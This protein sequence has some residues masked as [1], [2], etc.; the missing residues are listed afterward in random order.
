MEL[1][2]GFYTALG[3]PLDE[4]GNLVA[5]SLEKHIENQITVAGASGLLLMGS[6][7]IEAYLKNDTFKQTAMV[8][9]KANA[10]RLPLFVGAM[11][12]SVARVMEKI[13]MLK[14]LDIDGV[15]LTTPYYATLNDNEVV[16]WFTT[17]ADKSPFPIYLYDLAVITKTKIKLCAIEA[18]INHKN[19][20]GIKTA[21]WELITA[22]ERKFPD[23][24]FACLYSGLDNFDYA[25][26]LGITKNLDGMFCCMPKTGRAMYDCIEAGDLKGARVHLD[27]ILLLRNTM[28]S[29]GLMQS[30]TFLMNE[31]GYEGNFHQDY[32]LPI[33]DEA[34]ATLISLMK[35]CGEI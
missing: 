8:G 6:M 20:K 32:T 2:S 28:I 15:V 9:V 30:F 27:N 12:N 14:G 26:M 22:I 18:L 13:D 33:T 4:C 3:T 7:G 17:I 19:I 25:N 29:L 1:K 11:D 23:A 16:N 5:Q 24:D 21:D 34:K 10:G 35:K 31:L